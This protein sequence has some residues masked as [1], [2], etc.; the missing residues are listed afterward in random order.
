MGKLLEIQDETLST[1]VYR[2]T[3]SGKKD[4]FWSSEESLSEDFNSDS[5]VERFA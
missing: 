1:G 2:S 3:G 5:T 4:N